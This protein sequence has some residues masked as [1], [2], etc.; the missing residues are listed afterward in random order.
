MIDFKCFIHIEW[1]YFKIIECIQCISHRMFWKKNRK[2]CASASYSKMFT[3]MNE[4]Q[5]HREWICAV[6]VIWPPMSSLFIY[7]KVHQN[8][9][10]TFFFLGYT[11][12]FWSIANFSSIFCPI[13]QRISFENY[14][15]INILSKICKRSISINELMRA[16]NSRSAGSNFIAKNTI[17][18]V[19]IRIDFERAIK[20]SVENGLIKFSN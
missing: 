6:P 15:H 18:H 4:E 1:T 9:C 17:E 13:R 19:L 8:T 16:L 5:S 12:H 14:I 3:R 2:L 7:V 10:V 11:L 20:N